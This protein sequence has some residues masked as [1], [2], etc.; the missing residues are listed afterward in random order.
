VIHPRSIGRIPAVQRCVTAVLHGFIRVAGWVPLS[1]SRRIGRL[2]GR[3]AWLVLWGRRRIALE[4]LDAA[5]DD[6]LNEEEKKRIVRGTFENLGIVAMEFAHMAKAS[7][8]PIV[9]LTGREHFDESRGAIFVSAHAANWEWMAPAVASHGLPIAE[10]VNEYADS[11]RGDLIDSVRRSA[12][13]NTITKKSA[14]GTITQLLAQKTNI[15]IL[16]DQSARRNRVPTTFFGRPCWTTSGPA[17]LAL[18]KDV[19]IHLLMMH[20]D[21]AGDYVL[22]ASPRVQVERSGDF[23]RDVVA[24][25]Q[26]IQDLIEEHVRRYPD[27]WLWIHKRWKVRPDLRARWADIRSG[28]ANGADILAADTSPPAS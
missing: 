7:A 18:R 24:L 13:V 21:S 23:R 22:E 3:L 25:T 5:F 27:Q 6:S 12:G 1:W 14:T 28:T 9:K 17:V 10:V 20:R 16:T 11:R 26:R 8:A 19:P 15:G 4:H 2:V